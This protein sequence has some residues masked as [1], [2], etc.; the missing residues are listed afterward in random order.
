[1]VLLVNDEENKLHVA[2]SVAHRRVG[3]NSTN[4]IPEVRILKILNGEHH[5]INLVDFQNDDELQRWWLILPYV[6][7]CKEV[8]SYSELWCYLVQLLEV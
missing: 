5:T 8:T 4:I 1:M 2:K 6:S 7:F 3:V